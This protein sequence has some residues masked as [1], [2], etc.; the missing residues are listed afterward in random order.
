MPRNILIAI[1]IFALITLASLAP[2]LVNYSWASWQPATCLPNNCFCEPL[3]AGFIRQ[4]INTYSNL[5]YIL[6]GLLILASTRSDPAR[7]NLLS[8]HR[9]YPLVFGG[10]TMAIGVGSFFYHASL[11]FVGQWFDLMGMYLFANF[12]LMYTLARLR[13]MR[14]ATFALGYI[15][16]NAILGYLLIVN[17]EVRRQVFAAMIYGVIALE[18]LVLLA[19]RPRIKT[20][21]FV[22]ALVSLVVAYGIW[23]LDESRV[24]CD[25]TS[26]LQGHALWHFL[27]AAAVGL[28]YLYYWSEDGKVA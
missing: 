7:A 20:R 1:A 8:S 25:P 14:G 4:P 17:P 26:V 18:A 22:G 16:M 23:L 5:A 9:A 12:A 10:A 2:A 24:W 15:V 27:T 6:V 28:L 13:P 3:R 11:T 19:E 21:Y